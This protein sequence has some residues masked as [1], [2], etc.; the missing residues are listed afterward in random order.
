MSVV[1][2]A[3]FGLI[4]KVAN[5]G[6]GVNIE[7]WA[8]KAVVDRGGDIIP[9]SAWRLENYQKNPIVLFNHDKSK[10][11]G[12]VTAVEARD[13]GLYVKARISGSA[14][15]EIAKIRDLISEGVLNAFSVGFDMIDSEAS[16][17][18]G[19]TE[20]KAAELFELSVVALPMNQ[21]S[22]FSVAKVYDYDKVTDYFKAAN[23]GLT[24]KAA[25]DVKPD[26]EAPASEGNEGSDTAD[27]ADE[28]SS[29][30]SKTE[31]K[32][33]ELEVQ[34]LTFPK[35]EFKDEAAVQEWAVANG[36]E[37]EAI[38]DDGDNWTLALKP[39]EEFTN[40]VDLPL[41]NG[42]VAK[43]GVCKPAPEPMDEAEA[44]A[45]DEADKTKAQ[46]GEQPTEPLPSQPPE[47]DG[48]E[49]LLLARQ[50]NVLL[51]QVV[52]ELQAVKG[53]I[54]DL[55]NSKQPE[56][57]PGEE[58]KA[59]D[60]EATSDEDSEALAKSTELVTQYLT[61]VRKIYERIGA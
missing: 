46:D 12:K 18:K 27:T 15:P 23:G 48:N 22:L 19:V 38:S 49:S 8:N 10:P 57:T 41:D 52:A 14:D 11:I 33:M 17:D 58:P 56:P 5:S 39:V 13:E 7:G 29:E 9:K 21:D 6:K 43:V 24:T 40:L 4:T 36:W 50:M 3:E 2:K 32:E 42:V 59:A 53:A 35:S 28:A 45:E 54:I 44:E 16:S 1:H 30:D 26:A 51:G 34:S 37:A 25:G 61:S 31:G 47:T 55:V 60:T 20:I